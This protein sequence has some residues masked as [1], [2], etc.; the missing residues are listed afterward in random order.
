[1]GVTYFIPNAADAFLIGR[2][3]DFL[4][5]NIFGKE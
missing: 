3:R 1:M 4:L 2:Y 5:K